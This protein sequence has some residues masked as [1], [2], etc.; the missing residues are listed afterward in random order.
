[1]QW[2]KDVKKALEYLLKANEID[3]T[4]EAVYENLGILNLQEWVH[5]N[6]SRCCSVLIT[7]NWYFYVKLSILGYDW[8]FSNVIK[9][10]FSTR[11]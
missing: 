9:L 6:P 8:W 2:K 4:C 5:N 3:P 11:K 10:K 1:M 7:R